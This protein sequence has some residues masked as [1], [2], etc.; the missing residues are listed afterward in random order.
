MISE[1]FLYD[2]TCLSKSKKNV[3]TE[4]KIK[5][6]IERYLASSVPY[7]KESLCRFYLRGCCRF[8]PSECKYAH[9]IPDLKNFK[10]ISKMERE[11]DYN[12]KIKDYD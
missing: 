12:Y 7:E 10:K 11:V 2:L 9:D 5:A 3:M 1:Y 8:T 6:E 4:E